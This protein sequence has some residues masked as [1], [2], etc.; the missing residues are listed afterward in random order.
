LAKQIQRQIPKLRSPEA[1]KARSDLISAFLSRFKKQP[2]ER[3]ITDDFPNCSK[4]EPRH[5]Y[6]EHN[7][8]GGEHLP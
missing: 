5:K 6:E 3:L 7:H 8:A 1:P 2:N 4:G